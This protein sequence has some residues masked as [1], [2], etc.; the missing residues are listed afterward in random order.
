VCV[1]AHRDKQK[2]REKERKKS[3]HKGRKRKKYTDKDRDREKVES[4][5]AMEMERGSEIDRQIHRKTTMTKT[6]IVKQRDY[7]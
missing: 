2:E 5:E 3:Q 7:T 4:N 1:R 6:H